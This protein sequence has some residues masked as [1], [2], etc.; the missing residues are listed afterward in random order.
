MKSGLRL[1]ERK[2]AG[3]RRRH[4]RGIEPTAGVDKLATTKALNSNKLLP[5]QKTMSVS[6]SVVAPGQKK[7]V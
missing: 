2:K 1:A 6:F 5:E 7:T 3:T 4:M